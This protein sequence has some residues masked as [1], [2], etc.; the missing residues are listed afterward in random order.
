MADSFIFIGVLLFLYNELIVIRV[1][2]CLIYFGFKKIKCICIINIFSFLNSGCSDFRQAIGKEKFIPNE[3]SF[4][5]TPN[6][7]CHQNLV[8][9]IIL[10]K[11]ES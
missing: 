6:L 10:L 8:I 5:S 9:K 11:K 3:Y 4:L 2:K 7:L 1:K